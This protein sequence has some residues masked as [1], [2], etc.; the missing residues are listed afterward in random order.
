MFHYRLPPLLYPFLDNKE[1]VALSGMNRELEQETYTLRKKRKEVV[2]ANA[3]SSF[4]VEHFKLISVHRMSDSRRLIR[5]FFTF[6]P[7]L[8]VFLTEKGVTGLDLSPPL[9]EY[10]TAEECREILGKLYAIVRENRTLT[11]CNLRGFEQYITWKDSAALLS[12]HPTLS[13]QHPIATPFCFYQ[14]RI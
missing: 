6:L 3:L 10:F 13:M 1:L 7:E 14:R 11:Y 12:N 9:S 2:A 8:G 4:Y 5:R